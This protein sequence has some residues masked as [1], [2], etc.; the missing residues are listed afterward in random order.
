MNAPPPTPPAPA[1]PF[2]LGLT[3]G[4]GSGKS[5]VAA[6]LAERGATVID[7]DA[8]SRASTAPGGAALAPIAA[9]FGAR[10]IDAQGALDRA[11]MR[12]LVYEDAS[13][14][15]RLEAI[16]HPLVIQAADRQAQAAADRGARCI[17]F[18]VPLLVEAGRRWRDRVTQVLVV[19]CPVPTQ[20]ARVMAR[21]GLSRAEVERIV[22]AQASRAQRLAAA[23][24][25]IDN[26]EGVSLDALRQ[27][28]AA[29]APRF[30][31]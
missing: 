2:R 5:T 30:G 11:A 1:T 4:I 21:S 6:L 9:A 25:V 28:V 27:S 24:L 31:L 13:A 23:D 3:G 20:I 29:L 7:T 17:V 16:I 26:G 18:D 14:R 10:F 19:D 22:A 12:A 8:L 15:Q